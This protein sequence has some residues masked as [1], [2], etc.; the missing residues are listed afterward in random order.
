MRKK[1]NMGYIPAL[2]ARSALY[3]RW[4]Q[5]LLIGWWGNFCFFYRISN[6]HMFLSLYPILTLGAHK[7]RLEVCILNINILEGMCT[8]NAHK[9][10][11]ICRFGV[12]KNCEK[13]IKFFECASR[14]YVLILR[15]PNIYHKIVRKY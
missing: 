3:S 6:Y 15:Q 4:K 2:F 13:Q 5:S 10:N 11:F 8:H 9:K 12:L 1:Q 7:T 14:V